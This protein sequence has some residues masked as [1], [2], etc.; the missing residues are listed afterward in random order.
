[1]NGQ[2]NESRSMNATGA[3]ADVIC[4]IVGC[5]ETDGPPSSVL[6]IVNRSATADNPKG[7]S[8]ALLAERIESF[9]AK[10][11]QQL[12]HYEPGSLT[13]MQ[14]EVLRKVGAANPKLYSVV[15]TST[16][17][18]IEDLFHPASTHPRLRLNRGGRRTLR[19]GSGAG[20]SRIFRGSD[21]NEVVLLPFKDASGRYCGMYLIRD[22]P[23]PGPQDVLF[24]AIGR[25]TRYGRPKEAGLSMLSLALSAAN[26]QF[27]NELFVMD[28]PAFATKLQLRNLLYFPQ[29][30]PLVGA[31]IG[32][33]AETSTET[34]WAL[35][36]RRLVFWT[37]HPSQ[38][39]SCLAHC[40]RQGGDFSEAP[41]T[42]RLRYLDTP[43]TFLQFL[44]QLAV[45]WTVALEKELRRGTPD[46]AVAFLEQLDLPDYAHT[47]FLK[48]LEPAFLNWLRSAKNRTATYLRYGFNRFTVL[49]RDDGWYS[50]ADGRALLNARVHLDELR[51]YVDGR[52]E[53]FGS[54]RFTADDQVPFS[55]PLQDVTKHGL[56]SAATSR[57]P[58]DSRSRVTFDR[59]VNKQA[60]S[61][62][63]TFHAVR[64]HH[65]ADYVGFRNDHR[66][67]FRRFTLQLGGH[68][69]ETLDHRIPP[70]APAADFA[71]PR[72]L[73][74][75]Q[76]DRF[77]RRS[78]ES[79]IFWAM[80]ACVAHNVLGPLFGQRPMGI[81]LVG[82][83][84][85]IIGHEAARLLGC[86]PVELPPQCTPKRFAKALTEASSRQGWPFL[87]STSVLRRPD[88]S[89]LALSYLQT[90]NCILPMPRELAD[91]CDPCRWVFIRSERRFGDLAHLRLHAHRILPAYFR[92]L[93]CRRGLVGVVGAR[94]VQHYLYDLSDWF[95][96]I[97]GDQ[98]TVRRASHLLGFDMDFGGPPDGCDVST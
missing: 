23:N 72:P 39:R 76:I 73:L 32:D 18:M 90:P 41:N 71:P 28:D 96:R 17:R 22:L 68:V 75:A 50:K 6:T 88:N 54:F 9:L 25:T 37:P 91:T 16:A 2:G 56:L 30:L 49:E 84:A 27:A 3:M 53:L 21:W 52:E 86:L 19:R 63:N 34:Y 78:R 89:W 11:L 95:G 26:P 47:R 8:I 10:S 66:L 38:R 98:E 24:H 94:H 74:R 51:Q 13:R 77:S 58:A 45:P 80:T 36:R 57:L 69:E 82:D 31:Y 7:S 14:S 93:L 46:Q 5:T 83:G 12:P 61:I 40:C 81:G 1:M 92:D 64:V 60:M 4:D 42:P 65:Q 35:G 70:T 59:S 55:V 97:G 33:R 29:P 79:R 20:R 43:A 85:E 44:R 67:H 15:G 48:G 62:A 87:A